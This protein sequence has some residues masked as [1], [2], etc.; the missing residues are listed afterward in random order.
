MITRI[1]LYEMYYTIKSYIFLL[2]SSKIS[3]KKLID[4]M[5]KEIEVYLP[6]GGCIYFCM[7]KDRIERSVM[8]R[9]LAN[10]Q[11]SY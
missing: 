7:N 2:F 5:Y 8:K 3:N 11:N 9:G 10:D 4:F 6:D 1:I